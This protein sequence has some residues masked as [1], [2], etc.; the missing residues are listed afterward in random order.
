ML[1]VAGE[2]TTDL[3]TQVLVV[4][5]QVQLVKIDNQQVLLEAVEL[6]QQIQ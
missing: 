6:V 5:V 1:V 3:L 2:V 4:E